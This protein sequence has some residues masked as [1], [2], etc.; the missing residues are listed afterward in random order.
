MGS[1]VAQSGNRISDTWCFVIFSIFH[2]HLRSFCR[3]NSVLEL[4][5]KCHHKSID[6]SALHS[7]P[8]SSPLELHGLNLLRKLYESVAEAQKVNPR[9]VNG[10][11]YRFLDCIVV[12]SDNVYVQLAKTESNH[13]KRRQ[14]HD[15]DHAATNCICFISHF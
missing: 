4:D 8:V 2:V 15:T 12:D 10:R 1:L 7:S 13:N 3:I 6:T 14:G 9:R 11:R 5:I